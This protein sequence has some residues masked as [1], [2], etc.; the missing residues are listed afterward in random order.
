MGTLL[1]GKGISEPRRS[2][3]NICPY[4]MWCSTNPSVIRVCIDY[5]G[6]IT[7]VKICVKAAS[8]TISDEVCADFMWILTK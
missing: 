8:K 7:R 4:S 6:I 5:K 3:E 2:A 1:P